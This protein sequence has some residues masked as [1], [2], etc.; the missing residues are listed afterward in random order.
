MTPD[1]V[2]LVI[3]VEESRDARTV[4]VRCPL[5]GAVHVHG[6]PPDEDGAPG[7]RVAHCGRGGY[8]I[9]VAP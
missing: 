4:R 1:P 5:C 7:H 2:A 9:E 8:R 3:A 6:W